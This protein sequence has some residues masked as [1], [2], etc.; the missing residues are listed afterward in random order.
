MRRKKG[1]DDSIFPASFDIDYVRYYEFDY[2]KVDKETPSTI[3]QIF[4]SQN[5][6]FLYWEK[7]KDDYEIE[8]YNIYINNNF[9]KSVSL[10]QFDL[11]NIKESGQHIIQV[12]AVDFTKKESPL[13]VKFI[14]NK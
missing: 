9:Y 6:R 13:S 7:P 8:K 2:Q 3:N 11:H 14:Y 12:S 4:Q 1:I 5:K 10:N